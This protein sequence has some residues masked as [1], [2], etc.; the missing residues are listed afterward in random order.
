M[1]IEN[2]LS[3]TCPQYYPVTPVLSLGI[4]GVIVG[5]VAFVDVNAYGQRNDA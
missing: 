5:L 2:N 4:P 1:N 3:T